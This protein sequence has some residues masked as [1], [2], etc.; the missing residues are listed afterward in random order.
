VKIL[1]DHNVPRP[2]AH[3][4]GTHD[5]KTARRMGWD[6]TIFINL[7]ASTGEDEAEIRLIEGA[8]FELSGWKERGCQE[9]QIPKQ[10]IVTA[11]L[12]QLR[13]GG[14]LQA[15]HGGD[16]IIRGRLY[17]CLKALPTLWHQP[18]DYP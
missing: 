6:T 12:Y 5:V 1:F 3:E 14:V 18:P 10:R 13:G 7:E 8:K 11:C 2:L 9:W 16:Q 15:D 17:T 4:L